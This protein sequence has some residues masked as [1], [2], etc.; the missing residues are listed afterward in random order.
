[1]QKSIFLSIEI[2]II[3]V[4]N[5][6]INYLLVKLWDILFLNIF[7]GNKDKKLARHNKDLFF[8]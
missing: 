4:A 6:S 3:Q 5:F 7:N 1:M 8:M 2:Y